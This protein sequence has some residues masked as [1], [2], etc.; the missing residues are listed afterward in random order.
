MKGFVSGCREI[1]NER[2]IQVFAE[3]AVTYI[4]GSTGYFTDNFGLEGMDSFHI[5]GFF[6]NLKIIFSIPFTSILILL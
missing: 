3:K 1:G 4:E 6:D 5:G 2:N